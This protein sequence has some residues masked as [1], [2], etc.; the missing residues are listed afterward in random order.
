LL[1]LLLLL[2]LLS[3]SSLSLLCNGVGC[4]FVV[5][6]EL[7]YFCIYLFWFSFSHFSCERILMLFTCLSS[8]FM[9]PSLPI[10]TLIK[11][12]P[13]CQYLPIYYG[14]PTM[15]CL[16]MSGTGCLFCFVLFCLLSTVLYFFCSL[17]VVNVCCYPLANA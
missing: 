9:R 14:L 4:C 16:S 3:S 1:L 6:L 12:L 8:N 11:F 15:R 5:F 13:T 10:T 17:L 2:L 7:C